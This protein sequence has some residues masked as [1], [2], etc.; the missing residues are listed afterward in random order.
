MKID[1]KDDR[2]TLSHI[3]RVLPRFWYIRECFHN[4]P[5]LLTGREMIIIMVM[6]TM[7]VMV[8]TMVMIT[9]MVMNKELPLCVFK[10]ESGRKRA[11]RT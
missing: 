6:M 1:I 5:W 3:S 7:M 9:I 11:I 4:P 10:I 2:Q 8:M